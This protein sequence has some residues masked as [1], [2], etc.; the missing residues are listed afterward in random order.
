[1]DYIPEPSTSTSSGGSVIALLLAV[2]FVIYTGGGNELEE[3]VEEP[4]KETCWDETRQEVRTIPDTGTVV[5]S[6][7]QR[8]NSSQDQTF[9][10]C[11]GEA[12]RNLV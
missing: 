12:R 3:A 4:A 6:V 9:T 2:A 7:V 8:R 10:V 1:M 5:W 11:A